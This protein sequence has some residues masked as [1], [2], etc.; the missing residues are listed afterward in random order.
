MSEQ[1]S[2]APRRQ[3]RVAK[4]LLDT[5]LPQLAHVFDYA[6]PERLAAQIQQGM[7]VKVPL[8]GKQRSSYGWVVELA[9][10]SSYSGELAIIDA[11]VGEV[12]LLTPQLWELAQNLADRAAGSACDIL[13]LAIPTRH[14]RAERKYLIELPQTAAAA[15]TAIAQLNARIA[16]TDGAEML[17][18]G[19]IHQLPNYNPEALAEK[20]LAG[21]KLA[22][23]AAHSMARLASDEWVGNWAVTLA[24]TASRVLAAGK[25]VIICL[26]D[27]RDLEQLS[28]ALTVALG[29]AADALV[30]L[31]AKQSAEKRFGNYLQALSGTPR[32][33]IGNRSAVYAPAANL[34]A[35]VMWDEADPLLAEP[36]APYVHPRDAAL[37]RQKQESCGLLF[38][39]HSRSGE[40]QRLLD[41]GYLQPQPHPVH[42]TKIRHAAMHVQGDEFAGRIPEAAL[43]LIRQAA[44]TGPVLVQVAKPGYASAVVCKDCRSRAVCGRC[45]G[46]L[47][48]PQ[49]AGKLQCLWCLEPVMHWR[50]SNCHG[51]TAH[52]AA[53]GTRMTA[54][55]LQQQLRGYRIIVADGENIVTRV[56][57]RSAI[58]VATVGAEPLAAGGYSA[59]VLLDAERLLQIPTLHAAEDCLRWWEN[60]AA[61]AGP[62]AV[63]L[64]AS[65]SGP[66]V[67]ALLRGTAEQWLQGELRERQELRYPPMVRVAA[68]SGQRADVQAA[69]T[70]LA[71]I[72]ECDALDPVPLGDGTWRAVVR[73]SYRAAAEVA[74][75]LRGQ[76]L[77]VAA[78]R[79]TPTKSRPNPK[80]RSG[81]RVKFDDRS[82][83]DEPRAPQQTV[84]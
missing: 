3:P 67:T 16:A 45:S 4:V 29:P 76:I 31:D 37:Q 70:A 57:A 13:R 25:S 20:L 82:I 83:F 10:H 1:L 7:R 5:R 44:E 47:G 66:V 28:A 59:V 48:A 40:I 8:R 69:L 41:L 50:C 75:V 49:T 81:L 72:A 9:Q 51:K 21:E 30:R 71:E 26:P 62:Q 61:K 42:R 12:P 63:C 53:P 15:E 55:R 78:G 27:W 46:P 34:G 24:A 74:K 35:I 38:F 43:R 32:I 80:M 39:G 19:Q 56:D 64:L 33:I 60:A 84:L 77:A 65:G 68:V 2:P 58:V 14:A 17:A 11:L 52:L 73:C 18:G 79:I 36:L 23:T 54:E 6:I 22:Y